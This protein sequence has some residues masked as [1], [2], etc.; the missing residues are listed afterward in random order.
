MS[1]CSELEKLKCYELEKGSNYAL[2]NSSNLVE[3]AEELAKIGHYGIS[4]SLLILGIEEAIK[5][6][7]LYLYSVYGIKDKKLLCDVFSKHKTKHDV[8][9]FIEF[10]SELM[11]IFM[12]TI[13]EYRQIENEGA[14]K[15]EQCGSECLKMITSKLQALTVEPSSNITDII[16]WYKTANNKKNQ[17]FYV[18]YINQNWITPSNIK[19]E[20]CSVGVIK[21]KELINQ[22]TEV[23]KIPKS[24][25]EGIL[26]KV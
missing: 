8:L 12:D 20:D 13:D 18:D 7:V 14:L 15:T 11:K 3:S 17:G 23:K 10:M 6:Y 24:E 16:S 4:N 25:L 19:K 9:G 1:R 26:K 21:A 2:E 22:L 5:S